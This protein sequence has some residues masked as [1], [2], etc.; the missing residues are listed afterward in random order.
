MDAAKVRARHE[1]QIKL[2]STTFGGES[3]RALTR[4]MS[5][6]PGLSFFTDDQ[7][8]EVREQMIRDALFGHR[9]K[10]ENRKRRTA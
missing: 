5:R 7:I 6:Y 1:H 3:D 9:L 8:A 10:R 4:V 2:L